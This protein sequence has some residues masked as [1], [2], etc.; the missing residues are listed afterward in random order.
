M[1]DEV[2]DKVENALNLVMNTTEQSGNMKKALKQKIFETVSTLRSLFVKLRASGDSKTSEINKLTKQ[3]GK[4]EAELKQCRDMQARVHQ[5][6]SLAG[7]TILDDT[8]ARKHGT[9]SSASCPEPAGAATRCVALPNDKVGTLYA[10]A[11]QKTK[12]KT[13]KMTVRS[14]GA[15]P[16]ESIKQLLKA[17]INPNEITVGI[18][19]FKTLSSGRVLIETNGKEEIEA[20]DKEIQAK[21]GGDLEVNTHTLKKPRLLILNVPE[22]IST[23]NIEDSIL[24]QNPDPNLKRGGI[25]AK[26]SYITKK[27][28]R[29]LVVEV[30][31][32]PGRHYYIGR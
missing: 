7:E 26:F 19:T 23:T 14:K 28:N 29:N 22:D 31:R 11:V 1:V 16:P 6:S 12:A 8:E 24:M 20:L 2:G 10:A 27:M 17:K 3:V 9:P 13:Y 15:H 4:L 18:N 32:I 25:A 30:G 5:T 21:C